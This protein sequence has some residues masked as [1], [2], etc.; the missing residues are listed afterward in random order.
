[1]IN[2]SNHFREFIVVVFGIDKGQL[3]KKETS[4]LSK[5]NAL[6]NIRSF[7]TT[8]LNT[9]RDGLFGQT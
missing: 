8:L 4:L 9:N 1:V 5:S 6:T 7:P 2:H 3:L